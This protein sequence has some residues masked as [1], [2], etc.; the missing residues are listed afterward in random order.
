MINITDKKLCSG[1]GACHD[2]CPK[3]AISLKEDVEGARYPFVNAEKCVNCGICDKVCPFVNVNNITLPNFKIPIFF[4]SQLKNKQELEEVSSGGAFWALTQYIISKNGVVYGAVQ[5]NV[6]KIMHIRA[7]NIEDAKKLRRSKYFQSDTTGIYSKVKEDLLKGKTVLFSGVPC[8]IAGLY[9][10]LGKEYENL[11]TCEVVCHGVPVNSVW[12]SYRKEKEQKL[13]KKIVDLVFRDKSKGWAVNQYKIIYDDR[14][15]EYEPSVRN[16]FHRG[17]LEGFFYRPSCGKCPFSKLPRVADI[18]LAD[19]WKYKGK[20]NEICNM[21]VSLVS[22]NNE[23]GLWLLNNTSDYLEIERTNSQTALCSCRHLNNCP[24]ENIKRN[25]F[26]GHLI[27]Y[28]YQSAYEKYL[29]SSKNDNSNGLQHLFQMLSIKFIAC[30]KGFSYKLKVA[31]KSLLD[32]ITHKIFKYKQADIDI[33]NK[34]YGTM[35]GASCIYDFELI[36]SLKALIKRDD[37]VFLSEN[38]LL[39]F[40]FRLRKMNRGSVSSLIKNAKFFL[41]FRD[42]CVLLAKKGV[43]VYFYNRVGLKKDGF[44]YSESATNRM[45]NKLSFPLM[46]ENIDKYEKDL[47]E[48]FGDKY[49]KEYVEEIGKIPQV[50]QVGDYYCHEDCKSRYVNVVDGKRITCFQPENFKR[51]IH[52]YGRC[53]AFGYAVE[54]SE[55]LPS[56]IQKE[57]IENGVTDIKVVNH[58]LWGGDNELIDSNFFKDLMSFGANDIVLFYRMHFDK[59]IL[60]ELEHFGLWYHEITEDWHKFPEAKNCFYDKPGHMNAAGYKNAAKLIVKD[61]IDHDFKNKAVVTILLKG[62]NNKYLTD[63]LKD[64]GNKEFYKELNSYIENINRCYP[65][66]KNCNAGA[67]VMNCNPFTLG[68]RKLIE[69]ASNKVDKLYIFVVQEDKS[70]F[71]FEDRFEMVKNG[72]ADLKNVVVIPSGKFIISAFT[73]PEYF[74]KDYVKEKNFDVSSDIQIFCK[75]IAPAFNIKTRFAGEEPFDPVTL[76]YNDTM[77]KILPEYGMKFCEIPRF[78]NENKEIINATKVRELL[79]Q[80]EVEILKTYVPASTL[81]ILLKKYME[82]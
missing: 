3:K 58:G 30:K 69:Y 72:V 35:L 7:E 62:F 5:K 51:T 65:N 54:D 22:V 56:Q 80:K 13:G 24:S 9:G 41:T 49:S 43:P 44:A 39:R 73:F 63:F 2:I 77:R 18:T 16:L 70:F 47:K 48:I 28:G 45:K 34:Y 68:H 38:R 29:L 21:G 26:I 36:K 75:Y 59:R 66:D 79:K 57:L 46:H 12:R 52:I 10:F 33:I 82:L 42:A 20:L 11:Y 31:I 55:T 32:K 1:C 76:N 67:I 4:A 14:S 27:K 40:L 6:D 71:K 61:L 23:K 53:G 64:T 15:V 17:Y 60:A 25:E 78:E 37:S 81:E 8:Q 50:I 19:F 74:M